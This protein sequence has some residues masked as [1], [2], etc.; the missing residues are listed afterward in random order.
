MDF[1]AFYHMTQNSKFSK[2]SNHQFYRARATARIILE[3]SVKD[4][5]EILE[6]YCK[7]LLETNPGSTAKIQTILV[8]GK[9]VF[10]KVYICLKACKDGFIR[11]C[12]RLI[13]LDGCHLKGYYK[14]ILLAAIGI[15]GA[16]SIFL[17]A[18]AVV[19][20]ETTESWTWFLELLKEDL[21]PTDPCIY[22]MMSDRKK[23][24]QNAVDK[25]FIGSNGHFC[26]RHMHGNFKK[27]FPGLLL[28]QMLWVTARATT[29]VDFERKMKDLKDVNERAYNWL[30][31]K[32]PSEWSKSHFKESVKCDMLLNN[33]TKNRENVD[34]W[35]NPV[36]N[37]IMKILDKQ[38]EISAYCSIERAIAT[39]F[40]VT[41]NDGKRL[42]V[43]L[44]THTCTCRR[45]QLTGLPCGHGLATIFFA[46]HD[47]YGDIFTRGTTKEAYEGTVG[48]VP[49]PNN[50]PN[51][52]INPIL[53]PGENNLPGRPKKKRNLIANEPPPANATKLSKKGQMNHCGNCGQVGHSRRTCKNE[54]AP[55][56]AT[57]YFGLDYEG[58]YEFFVIVEPVG[59]RPKIPL[60]LDISWRV[61]PADS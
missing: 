49:S 10:E 5:Y 17:I 39:I 18:Y 24:L 45:W 47:V 16:N 13:G 33:F 32:N 1:S 23:G 61:V 31:P 57:S 56:V 60:L 28:K 4:Q 6:D 37:N 14:G 48:P 43:D 8:D 3:G 26:V 27:D 2:V 15:D 11:G 21:H 9:R 19:G 46:K 41:M 34:K 52:G 20:K 42:T 35:K 59:K 38:M 54:A 44:D 50:W 12:R 58:E 36:H 55:T 51:K 30:A 22:T 40:Q 7:Q 53:P 29:P 25:I